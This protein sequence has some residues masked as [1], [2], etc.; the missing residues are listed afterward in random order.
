MKDGN[1]QKYEAEGG[2]GLLSSRLTVQGP[3]EKNKSSFI[4]SGR[5]TYV[6]VLSKPF[7]NEDNA[8]N[9]SG[10]YFYDLTTKVN[11]KIDDNDRIYLSGYF[12]RDVFSFSNSDNDI[13][14]SIPCGIATTSLRWILLF[15][16]NLFMNT[17]LILGIIVSVFIGL[18]IIHYIPKL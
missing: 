12:G 1:N 6:D 11:Y 13:A 17:S 18:L 3:L 16:D 8:F 9:G 7:L 10:Y 5:R 15:S 4:L 2:I 14:I